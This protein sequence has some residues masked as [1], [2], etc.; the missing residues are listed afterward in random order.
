[1]LKTF[2]LLTNIVAALFLAITY[3]IPYI[4]PIDYQKIPFLGL[5]YPVLLLVNLVYVIGWAFTSK[6]QYA[7]LS[8]LVIIIGIRHLLTLVGIP[9]LQ[10]TI[11][12]SADAIKVSSYNTHD[13]SSVAW[14]NNTF[15][16]TAVKKII[17]HLGTADYICAQEVGT[18][19]KKMLKKE[20]DYPYTY[21]KKG[22]MIFARTPFLN[23]GVID[24]GDTGN[25]CTWADVPFGKTTVRLY[26]LHLESNKITTNSEKI[27]KEKEMTIQ[28][29]VLLLKSMFGQYLYHSRVRVEQTEQVLAHIEDSPY[30]VVVCGD[31]N[32]APLSYIYRRFTKKLSDGFTQQG[33][34]VGISFRGYIPFLRIDYI[35]ADA[36]LQF[37]DYRTVRTLKYSDH[38]PVTA[39]IK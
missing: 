7:A 14:K 31:F 34:G 26:S 24:F 5:L 23:K 22:T 18:K 12:I 38:Y 3:V 25:S 35:L 1:M 27:L 13:F 4:N 11:T 37:Q 9:Y 21:G 36:S 20:L 39:V 29:R 8:L 15:Q 30:P 32:D 10:E 28:D 17:K 33:R 16:P 19:S 2:F 6:T